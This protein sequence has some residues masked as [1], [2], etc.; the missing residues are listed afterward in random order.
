MDVGDPSN[1]VRI[2]DL[3]NRKHDRITQH[4]HGYSYRDEEIRESIKDVFERCSYL[5]DPHGATGYRAA[6]DYRK[7]HP[8]MTGVFLETAHPAKFRETVEEVIKVPLELPQ[9]LAKFESRVKKS[10]VINPDYQE[11]RTWLLDS[12]RSRQ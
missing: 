6:Q 1:F 12:S 8:E 11:F 7:K 9:R 3:F 2:Q 4:L 5:C 10:L